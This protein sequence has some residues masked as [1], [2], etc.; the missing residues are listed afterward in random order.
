MVFT[1]YFATKNSLLP[2]SVLVQLG[3]TELALLSLYPAV[4]PAV[5]EK[6]LLVKPES[7]NF[8]ST[9]RFDMT[10]NRFGMVWY[11][12]VILDIII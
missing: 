12:I 4:L 10:Q 7:S 6:Y 3:W 1:D 11:I 9:S 5:P 2:S 8:V